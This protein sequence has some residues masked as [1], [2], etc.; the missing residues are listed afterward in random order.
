MRPPVRDLNIVVRRTKLRRRCDLEYATRIPSR[1]MHSTTSRRSSGRCPTM[2]SATSLEVPFG[3]W[4]DT[5]A[6]IENAIDV[7]LAKLLD[8]ICR[9]GPGTWVAA[10]APT[11]LKAPLA[12]S[13]WMKV[14]SQTRAWY[15]GRYEVTGTISAQIPSPVRPTHSCGLVMESRHGD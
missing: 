8:T 7:D 1:P 4:R 2:Y 12:R 3:L 9:D 11:R 5:G 14:R 6:G 10:P 13:E 15:E